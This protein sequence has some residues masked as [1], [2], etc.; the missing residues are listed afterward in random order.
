MGNWGYNPIFWTIGTKRNHRTGL[1]LLILTVTSNLNDHRFMHTK[2]TI[3]CT[4]NWG[5]TTWSAELTTNLDNHHIF[6]YPEL[7]IFPPWIRVYINPF[8]RYWSLKDLKV[9]L[10]TVSLG[11]LHSLQSSN[12]TRPFST[13]GPVFDLWRLRLLYT[14]RQ[15]HW[16]SVWGFQIRRHFGCVSDSQKNLWR[17]KIGTYP[18]W[19]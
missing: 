4:N 18:T 17:T 6:R 9:I 14:C 1:L 2:Q 8:N 3:N 19:N 11:F 10:S 15:K 16:L 5:Y 12:R 13:G 7:P